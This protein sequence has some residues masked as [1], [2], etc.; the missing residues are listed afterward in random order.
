MRIARRMLVAGCFFTGLALTAQTLPHGRGKAWTVAD[1]FQKDGPAGTPPR[2]FVWNSDG[3]TATYL[4]EDAENGNTGDVVQVNAGN[5]SP[6]VLIPAARLTGI[7]DV[8]NDERDRDHRARYGES[9]YH[10][11]PDGKQMLFDD[12]GVLWLYDFR[13]NTAEKIANSGSGSGDDPKFSPDG[14][15][16]SFVRDHNLHVLTLNDRHDTALTNTEKSTL[17]NGEVDWVYLE[18]LNARSNYFWS[19]DSRH[20]VYLQMDENTVPQYP[21]TNWAPIHSTVYKQRYPQPGDPNPGVRVGVVAASGGATT[22]LNIPIS[23]HNDYIPRFGWLNDRYVWVEVLR[24]DQ[25]QMDLYFAD[26][27]TGQVHKVFTDSDNKFLDASYDLTFL[28]QGHFL[29]SSWRSGHTHIYLYSYDEQDPLSRKAKLERQ[30][31]HGDWDVL[32]IVGVDEAQGIVYYTS[33]ETD[34]RQEMLWEIHLDG[35]GKKM[36]S[37]QP[38]VHTVSFSPDSSHYIDTFTSLTVPPRASICSIGGDCNTFWRSRPLDGYKLVAPIQLTAKAADGT[39][40]YGD[41]L[42][43]PDMQ[44]KA[45]VPLIVNPYGGP[46]VQTVR[47]ESGSQA[48]LFDQLLMQHDFAVLHTDNRG[49]SGRGRKFADTAYE[50]FGATQLQDQLV[51]VDQVLQRYPQLD[52]K[53]MGWWGW[54]WGGYFT[55][56]AM[57]HSDRF[58]AGVSVAPVTDWRLYDSIYT[59][60]YLELPSKNAAVY[61]EDSVTPDAAHLHGNLLLVHGTGD[62]NVHMQNS[63]QMVQAFV[64]ANVPYRML[65]YPGKTHSISGSVARTHLFDAI[66]QHFETNLK[67]IAARQ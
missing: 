6:S 46:G 56:Y 8:A 36:V 17:L 50:S 13:R 51:M 60:R 55:L 31:T 57:T 27:N 28:Q 42:L 5:G 62:D 19:S 53:R 41:L 63:I 15:S 67:P 3:K 61:R 2:I 4:S 18:E 66:F 44:R 33:N 29:W 38:G 23:E 21:I 65:L 22:W 26:T 59:E 9:S 14:K 43:P 58:A 24:R 20:I 11:S 37:T 34:P 39:V 7:Y 54:S 45:S 47:D 10:W 1:I 40:L 30:L 12:T 16:V 49:M 35:S 48:D 52:G 25:K 64:N 32:E